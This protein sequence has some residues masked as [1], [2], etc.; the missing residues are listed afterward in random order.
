[1]LIATPCLYPATRFVSYNLLTS[2][3]YKY[4][5]TCRFVIN[6]IVSLSGSLFIRP[7]AGDGIR[8]SEYKTEKGPATDVSV[9]FI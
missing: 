9:K 3:T 7:S 5:Y 8:M 1:M 6:L 2:S 4:V